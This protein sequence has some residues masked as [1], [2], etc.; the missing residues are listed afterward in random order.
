M[1]LYLGQVGEPS[2]GCQASLQM[3]REGL[4]LL[5]GCLSFTTNNEAV[6]PKSLSA[7]DRKCFYISESEIIIRFLNKMGEGMKCILG[8][9]PYCILFWRN[10]CSLKQQILYKAVGKKVLESPQE[11]K[12]GFTGPVKGQHSLRRLEVIQKWHVRELIPVASGR[13]RCS[14]GTR[15]PREYPW[16]FCFLCVRGIHSYSDSSLFSYLI[17]LQLTWLLC[18]CSPERNKLYL[19]L[20]F[21]TFSLNK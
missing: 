15:F 16:S 8:F 1:N 4:H 6:Y 10:K 9:L 17:S 13:S 14:K 12:I 3:K 19:C 7:C 5:C 2:W 11:I 21:I 20:D 18:V